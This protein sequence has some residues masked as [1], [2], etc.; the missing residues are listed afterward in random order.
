MKTALLAAAVLA[1]CGAAQA[2]DEVPRCFNRHDLLAKLDSKYSEVPTAFGLSNDGGLLELF[3]SPS[4]GW[5]L[6]VR[7]PGEQPCIFGA[8]E[9]WESLVVIAGRP[10]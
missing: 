2:A 10:A 1:A 9:R 5:T 6:V 8:G 7:Y 4:G 3:L